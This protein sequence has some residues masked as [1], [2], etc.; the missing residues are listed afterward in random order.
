MC[1]NEGKWRKS[2]RCRFLSLFCLESF[3]LEREFFSARWNSRAAGGGCGATG[4]SPAH[5]CKVYE[6]G[7]LAVEACSWIGEV[8]KEGGRLTT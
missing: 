3:I 8:G 5:Q 4:R 2:A 7:L 6:E 1:T